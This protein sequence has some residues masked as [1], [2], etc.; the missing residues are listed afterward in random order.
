MR[1]ALL[2]LLITSPC[3][4]QTSDGALTLAAAAR[5]ALA[6]HPTVRGAAAAARGAA[7]GVGEARSRW[8]PQLATEATLIRFEKPMVVTPIHGFEQA[9]LGQIAFD[10]TLIQGNVSLGFTVFDGGA[11]GARIRGARAEAA[12]QDAELAATE[13][14]V[15]ADVAT[16]FLD[17]LTAGEVAAAQEDG[18]R[19]LRAERDRV[20]RLVTEGEAA[21]VALLRVKAALAEAEADQI[22]ASTRLDVARR[23]LARAVDLPTLPDTLRAVRLGTLTLPDRD[24]LRAAVEQHNPRL[25]EASRSVEGARMVRR[26]ALAAWFPQL[27]AVGGLNVY[28]SGAGDFTTEWQ[29]GVRLSYPLFA[30][31]ARSAAVSRT[32]A[33]AAAAEDRYR[34]ALLQAEDALDGALGAVRDAAARLEAAQTTVIHL[35]D[36]ARIELLS[37]QA[38]A[39]TEV[40]YLRA[41]ADARRARAELATAHAAVITARVRLA[42]LTGE[43]SLDWLAQAM[44]DVP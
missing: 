37:L 13:A 39:G 25:R 11:R 7:A 10:R 42:Q 20:T 17:V 3:R 4:A 15:L 19:A 23:G 12:A 1:R 27:D 30:G 36:V 21:D 44:E 24:A 40:E 28:G 35:T 33:L 43:L 16:R 31:G 9:Q 38:G 8:F 22:S 26:A 29:A 34:L 5:R 6:V 2:L 32:G 14:D 41:E 18:V